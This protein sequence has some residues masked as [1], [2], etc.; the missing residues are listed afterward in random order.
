M[1]LIDMA[2]QHYIW[3]PAGGGNE[4]ICEML[5]SKMTPEAINAVNRYGQTALHMAASRGG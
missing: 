2:R 5:L 4:K 3:L 1:L